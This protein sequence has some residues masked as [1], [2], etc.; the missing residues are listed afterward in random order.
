MKKISIKTLMGSTIIAGSIMGV[1]SFTNVASAQVSDEI[2]VTGSRIARTEFTSAS[3][4]S[5]FDQAEIINSGQTSIDEFLKDIPAFTGFQL[6][7]STNNGNDGGKMVDLRGL[8]ITRT[9]VL[10]NGR[11]QVGSFVGGTGDVGAV[12]LNTI[13][14]G[15]VKRIEVLKDGASTAYGSDALSGV[16]NIILQDD[17]EGFEVSLDAGA[18]MENVDAVNVG[19]SA[20]MGVGNDRGNITVNLAYQR[21]EELLQGERAFAQDALYPNFDA[22]SDS[23][24]AVPSGSSNSRRIRGLSEAALA[25]IP[26]SG[27]NFIVD[28]TTGQ[29]RAFTGADVYNFAPIN[30][31]VTPNERHQFGLSGNYDIFDDSII[32]SVEAYSEALFTKR[33]SQQR[34][35]PDA[36]FGV[37]PDAFGSGNWND[38]VPASNPFNPFGVNPSNPWGVADE[39]VRIN[40]RF[41]ES[42]GRLFG[43]SAQTFR[44][45]TGIRGDFNENISY[46]LSYT[47]AENEMINETRNYGR[48]DR[49]AVAV[50]PAQC[51]A[52]PACASIT[53]PENAINPFGDFGS[54]TPEQMAY[55]STGSLKDVFKNNLTLWQ[56]VI[57]GDTS[58]S[59]E[60]AGGPVGYAVGFEQRQERASF[61]PDEFLAGGLTT[62]GASDPID[63]KY[64]VTEVFAEVLLPL[65]EDLNVE[66]SVR[67]S[68]YTTTDT[69]TTY[70]L[71]ADWAPTD[72]LFFRGGFSTGFRAPNIVELVSGESTGFPVVESLCEF[73]DIRDDISQ[74]V[75][76][77]CAALGQDGSAAG[78]YGFAWQSAY[79]T[80]P[81]AQLSPEESETLTLGVVFEPTFLPN[82]QLSL[83]Y[84][85]IQIDKYIGAPDFNDIFRNCLES[86][87]LSSP[88]CDLFPSGPYVGSFPGD[89][90]ANYGNLGEIKTDGFDF[91]AKYNRDVNLGMFN[92]LDLQLGG[93]YTNSRTESFPI[94]GTRETVGTANGFAVFPELRINASVGLVS[95]NIRLGWDTR[96]TSEA[97]DALRPAS[98]TDDA[99]AEAM[100]YHDIV[101]S[102]SFGGN[103]TV[104][105][106]INNLFDE[107]PP[108]FHSAFNA[109]TEPG[110]YDVIG[111]RMFVNLKS[112]F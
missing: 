5:V 50:D 110:I 7:A 13:P 39:D 62:G 32:G 111:R 100:T 46:D 61:N 16:V 102:V 17:F 87:N 94:A 80:L 4:I 48:F 1:T 14:M 15:M 9:L 47:F 33:T 28:S 67:N 43:Q 93:T 108:R 70:R 73:S 71:A 81:P 85:D 68:D 75:R 58:G 41:V 76:D 56:A 89:A 86:T 38:F 55:L 78:E 51:A 19:A 59:F 101:G 52:D 11:R 88:S 60:L 83:D 96:Y 29:A 104:T 91:N 98:I 82:L 77:N 25:L 31:L 40:R 42:G 105:A 2:V 112:S 35:A 18:G 84:W 37:T 23:F 63:G 74:T 3:P 57:N 97:D 26:G 20:L 36:S 44:V 92:G 66:A 49:W 64:D 53:G 24:V 34:L 109:N 12:D 65:T 107:Q 22:A 54:I 95:D 21:Q 79:T 8:G 27:S 30:A 103:Y 6:G 72:S 45:V 99:V 10:V 69:A 90:T 106:G